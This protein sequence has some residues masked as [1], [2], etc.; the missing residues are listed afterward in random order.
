M[1]SD[2]SIPETQQIE[3]DRGCAVTTNA[4]V[5]GMQQYE[6]SVHKRAIYCY[7]GGGRA[8]YFHGKG[9][10][11]GKTVGQ[12]HGPVTFIPGVGV[13]LESEDSWIEYALQPGG[14]I[15]GEISALITGLHV[16]SSTEDPKDTVFSI[17]RPGGAFND[18]QYRNSVDVRGNGAV[19][20][21]FLTNNGSDYIET[22][23]SA[24]RKTYTF[25]SASTYFA[26]ASWDGGFFDVLFR[27][28]G[29]SGNDVWHFG[30]TY[31]GSY[32]P[33][34]AAAYIGRP[35]ISGTRDSAS[36]YDGEIVRQLWISTRP[37]PA[38]ANK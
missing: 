13:R 15:T 19:A 23:G 24:E 28:G 4:F 21:R 32:N 1:F 9:L 18:N 16:R 30:K 34:P 3:R 11:A 10:H 31:R 26:K 22:V 27:E 29:F 8:R 2:L 17:Y 5:S 7:V 35:S 25:H 36:S 14:L 6:I 37:R 20:F 33:N 38:S 12:I